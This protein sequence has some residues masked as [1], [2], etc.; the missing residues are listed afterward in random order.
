M[1][2]VPEFDKEQLLA[3]KEVLGIYATDILSSSMKLVE[4]EH[5]RALQ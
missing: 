2:D 3:E 5:H 1:P 4:E